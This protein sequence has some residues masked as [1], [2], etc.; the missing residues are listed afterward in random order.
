MNSSYHVPVM[1]REVSENLVHKNDGIY[2]DGTLGGG[3]HAEF[4]LDIL[5]ESAKYIGVDRDPEAIQ[6]AKERLKRFKNFKAYQATFDQIDTVLKEEN[7]SGVDGVLLDLGISSWQIDQDLRGF[8]FRPGN[9][10]DMR[11]NQGQQLTAGEIVNSYEKEDL[12]RVFK[13]YGEE[14]YSGKIAGRIIRFR[15]NKTITK[16]QELTA[17]IDQCVDPRF[18]I[19]SYA[20]IFQALR[21][22]VNDELNILQATLDKMTSV[23]NK[24]GRLLVLTYHSLEDRIVKNFMRDME[25]P[26]TCPPELPVCVCGK[27]AQLKRHKPNFL[28]ASNAEIKDNS[29]ARSAKL[30]IAIKL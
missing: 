26:C 28:T 2:F 17:I 1:V 13:E 24:D 25:N 9:E 21:I 19:K 30:R 6:S 8:S 7:I 11:M 5:G 29:R 15:E 20:R 23:L 14:K 27:E 22:E 4:V 3:G 10:L 12:K 18:A 16:T